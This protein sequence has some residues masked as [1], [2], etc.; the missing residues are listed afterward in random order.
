VNKVIY[1][2]A[3]H[4]GG[5]SGAV[6]GKFI[7]KDINLS[8]A[9]ATR[10]YLKPYACTVVMNRTTDVGTKII[11]MSAQAKKVGASVSVSTHHNAGGGNGS[12]V[13]YWHSD[14]QAKQLAKDV[15]DQFSSLGQNEHGVGLKASTT[16]ASNFGM[17]RINAA[18]GIPAILGEF[19]F[20][21]SSDSSIIDTAKEIK[22]E[23]EAYG[24]AIVK[25]LGLKLLSEIATEPEVEVEE[26]IIQEATTK[27]RFP[28][29]TAIKKI[30]GI[31]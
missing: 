31:K 13:F 4:G 22:A 10:D 18:N 19:A 25:F 9:F 7:E 8:V 28:I 30:L 14:M 20:I 3:G 29:L 5:D 15:L 16:R 27:V 24:K 17:C 2:D 23:G 1:I 11:D 21:D 26:E 12:E 6:C